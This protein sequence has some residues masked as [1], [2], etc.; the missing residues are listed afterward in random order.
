MCWP[1]RKT[2]DS[3]D[4]I[5]VTDTFESGLRSGFED[6]EHDFYQTVGKGHGRMETRQCW[7]VSEPEVLE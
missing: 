1:S 4:E 3:P 7:V 5:G 2:R 6:L